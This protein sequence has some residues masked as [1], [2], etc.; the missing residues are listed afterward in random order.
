MSEFDLLCSELAAMQAKRASAVA[1]PA[2][3]RKSLAAMPVHMDFGKLSKLKLPGAARK[4]ASSPVDA[5]EALM[6]RVVHAT[7]LLKALVDEGRLTALQAATFEAYAELA[8]MN[9]GSRW[10]RTSDPAVIMQALGELAQ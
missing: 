7:S 10:L 2:R 1:R 9:W 4:T 6:N 8:E 3:L 5:R